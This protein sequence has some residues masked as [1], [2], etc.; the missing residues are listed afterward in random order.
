M[1]VPVHSGAPANRLA[2]RRMAGAPNGWMS[3]LLLELL[4]LEPRLLTLNFDFKD[5]PIRKRAS[6]PAEQTYAAGKRAAREADTDRL[7]F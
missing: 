5:S 7:S 6:Q 1:Q 3:S 2:Y 4:L